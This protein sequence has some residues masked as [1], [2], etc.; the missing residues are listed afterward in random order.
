MKKKSS[1]IL[2]V[3]SLFLLFPAVSF[4]QTSD[5]VAKEKMSNEIRLSRQNKSTRS[6]SDVVVEAFTDGKSDLEVMITGF[7]GTAVVQIITGRGSS[8]GYMDVYEMGYEV[9]NI[10][11]LR[12]GTYTLC[13]TVGDEVFEGT[14]EKVSVGR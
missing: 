8:Q 7:N 1:I 13:I 12:A 2:V 14:F 4:A 3:M 10:G 6:S 9:F 5:R 11:T